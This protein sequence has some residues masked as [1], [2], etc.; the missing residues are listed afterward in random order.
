MTLSLRR[1]IPSMFVRRL[2]LIALAMTVGLV[3]LVAQA[4]HLTMLKSDEFRA[5]A[6]RRLLAERWTP[7]VRGRIL[8][9][10]GRVLAH[11][12]PAFDVLVDYPLITGDAAVSWAAA[13][14][15]ERAGDEWSAL[16]VSQRD[17]L[18]AME[19]PAAEARLASLWDELSR[20]LRID[21][22]ELDE[23]RAEIE[24]TV[25]RMARSVW[26]R[27]LE[28]RRAELNRDRER[29]VEV[30]LDD[31]AKPVREQTIAQTIATGLVGEEVFAARRI[32]ETYEG[33]RL[34]PGGRRA[35]L[36]ESVVVDIDRSAFPP[37]LQDEGADVQSYEVHGVATHLVG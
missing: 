21:R 12:R 20:T 19:L 34:E 8:D 25:E 36:Y 17:A 29:L 3:V 23:R 13:S 35:Y 26:E 31:V 18:I 6:E 24:R 30:T 15:R 37:P 10:K 9:R 27:R 22:D 11:D 5:M 14:A 32:A 7:T 28:E 33:V 16:G 4:A 2:V 1:L